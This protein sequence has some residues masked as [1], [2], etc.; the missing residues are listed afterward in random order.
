ME[1]NL[2][3]YSLLDIL[4]HT[5]GDLQ[6]TD[7]CYSSSNWSTDTVRMRGPLSKAAQ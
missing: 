5:L 3:F 1:I 2:L 4:G 6:V 7:G